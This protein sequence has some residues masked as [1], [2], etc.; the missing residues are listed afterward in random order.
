MC[1]CVC[2]CVSYVLCADMCGADVCFADLL[3]CIWCVYLSFVSYTT[4]E[5]LAS[6]WY[7]YCI[8]AICTIVVRYTCRDWRVCGLSWSMCVVYIGVLLVYV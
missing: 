1:V 2:V 5:C 8:C 4:C 6:M 3:V 7:M